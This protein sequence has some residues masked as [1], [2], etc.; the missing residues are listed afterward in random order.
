[1]LK[2]CKPSKCAI[3]PGYCW[4]ILPNT[5][6]RLHGHIPTMYRPQTDHMPITYQPRTDHFPTAYQPRTDHLSTTNWPQLNHISSRYSN[7]RLPTTYRQLNEPRTDSK[8]TIYHNYIRTYSTFLR[9]NFISGNKP[10]LPWPLLTRKSTQ[11]PSTD[12]QRVGRPLLVLSGG[13][14]RGR[15]S[16]GGWWCHSGPKPVDHPSEHWTSRQNS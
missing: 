12:W 9:L 7:N 10:L 16:Q 6:R 8:P 2:I 15:W 5:H 1:M 3:L 13:P 14:R 4:G 11:D